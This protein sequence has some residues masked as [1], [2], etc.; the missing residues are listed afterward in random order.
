MDPKYLLCENCEQYWWR[1]VLGVNVLYWSRFF[2]NYWVVE[3]FWIIILIFKFF[4]KLPHVHRLWNNFLYFPL[5]SQFNLIDKKLP[6]LKNY[7]HHHS[8]SIFSQY[9]DMEDHA[10]ICD[11]IINAKIAS[12]LN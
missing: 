9:C 4:T 2:G 5:S 3:Y 12:Q 11:G 6:L 8:A 10:A 1:K 7:H